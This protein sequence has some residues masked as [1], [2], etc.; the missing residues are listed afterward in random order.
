MTGPTGLFGVPPGAD[1]PA[2]LVAGLLDRLGH[3]PPE[4]LARVTLYV[5]TR[6]MQR[7]VRALFDAGPARLLPQIR[8]ITELAS[9]A[10][11]ALPPPVPVLRRRLQLA[12][13]VTRLIELQP[14][15][16][17]RSSAFALAE[18]LA[19]LMDELQG[20][21]VGLDRIAALDVTDLSGHWARSQQFLQL[22]GQVLTRDPAQPSDPEARRRHAVEATLRDWAAHPPRH[23]VI[24]AGSTGSR[25]TT[26]LLMQAVARLP[27]GAVVLP[28][29][30]PD[31]PPE[32]W[33]RLLRPRL[34][35][36]HPQYRFAVLAEDLG[37]APG[38]IPPWQAG[39]A[40]PSARRN[41]LLSL[42]LRPA[43]VTDGWLRDGPALGDL[44]AATA[45]MTLL[46]AADPRTEAGALA[47]ILR[48]AVAEGK[49]A[50]L[51]SPDR[52][53]TR[54]VTAALDR[55]GLRPDDSAGE[56]LRQT[57]AGRFLRLIAGLFGTPLT[58]EALLILLKHPLT[59]QGSGR[60]AHMLYAHALELELRRNGPP[61]P[62]A[63]DLLAWAETRD[64]DT[65][66]DARTRTTWLLET[67]DGLPQIGTAPLAAHAARLRQVAEA[68]AAG[69][70][71]DPRPDTLW[72]GQDGRQA[73]QALD[74]LE[75][76]AGHGGDMDASDFDVLLSSVLG[77]EVRDP[78]APHPGVMI[79]GTLEARVQGA[80]LVLLAGLNDGVWP[81]LPQ[82]DP[83]LNRRMRTMAGLLS[84]ERRVGLSA[85]D[86]QQAAGAPQVV[87]SRA[88]RDAGAP[89]VPSRWINR[90]TNLMQGLTAQSGPE[91][92]TAMRAR[93]RHWLA[94]AALQD[95]PAGKVTA[96]ARPS[97]APPPAQRP[98]GLSVTQV[99]TLIRD[100]Y[101]I[102]A[103]HI[104]RL[105]MLD[106]LRRQPEARLRGTVLHKLMEAVVPT[107][108]TLPEPD[109]APA[110]LAAAERVLTA[111]VPWPAARRLWLARIAR[112][113]EQFVVDE[114]A[115]QGFAAPVAFECRGV[116]D[117]AA[118]P[119]RLSAKADR[120]D[121]SEDGHLFLYD[122]K[123]GAPPS[124]KEQKYFRRQ[125][126]LS[127]AI[128]EQSGFEGIAPAPVADARYL[129]LNAALDQVA[130][131]L[132]EA[133]PAQTLAE[134]SRL[135]AAWTDP[136]KGYTARLAR[137]RDSLIE[138]YDHLSR[139]GEWDVSD[140]PVLE[141]V[142]P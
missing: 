134:L 17:P 52:M 74:D 10:A 3:L 1:F 135:V 99:E 63:R 117:L 105:K 96:A 18:T 77:S 61:Y 141:H 76:E 127:A 51:I 106:P 136:A 132:A 34:I 53:L 128:A 130:A 109:R 56:P 98:T 70:A 125:L 79:W 16:A 24:V 28:G 102:Y 47:L 139:F 19:A 49:R 104:L 142:N 85:H 39:T 114:A 84:P 115:R 101:A 107:L 57:P 81:D 11:A 137:Q 50:A 9:P 120:I 87:L 33:Q 32:V 44:G 89:T 133:P 54:R 75:A 40:P 71:P 14:D 116:L 2:V 41:A 129:S 140:Q 100:P 91:A 83:W 92:L 123:S 97:P 94:L 58:A 95:R 59:A 27:Q 21:G 37:L 68:L 93:G 131:P 72:S 88:L 15:L 73:R 126:L 26:R 111:E 38:A 25:G 29:V 112:I 31:L 46:E 122:Y 30:D 80:D 22:V 64:G 82:P 48:H 43:P 23:P 62:D 8:L 13:L 6:R 42:A 12:Q 7:R 45:D 103:R 118:P 113:A 78:T 110:L 60:G 138:T 121:R 66:T 5:N 4:A 108:A 55:W 124:V 35:E 86:F 119:F 69:P 36:D 90:L 65:G 67:I 20:E